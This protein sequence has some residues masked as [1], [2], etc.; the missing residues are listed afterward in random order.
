M[1]HKIEWAKEQVKKLEWDLKFGEKWKQ[2][3]AEVKLNKIY[4]LTESEFNEAAIAS[5]DTH[6]D[7]LN[8]G[9]I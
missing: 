9:I 2:I 4:S 7:Y 1:E 3:Q 6:K 5:Y 8:K